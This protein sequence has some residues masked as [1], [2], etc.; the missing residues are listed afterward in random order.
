M[1][2]LLVVISGLPGTGKTTLGRRVRPEVAASRFGQRRRHPEHLDDESSGVELLERIREIA[3]LPLPDLGGRID[4]DT[5]RAP[6][7]ESLAREIRAA[8]S[9]LE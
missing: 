4:V 5:S 2:R 7:V 3:R 6:D 1:R 9:R 8:I